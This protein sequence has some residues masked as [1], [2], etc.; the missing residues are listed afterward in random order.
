MKS[1]VGAVWLS[2]LLPMLG[3][4]WQ[5]RLTPPVPGPF[6][7]LRVV[8]AEYGFGWNALPAAE[9]SF[10]FSHQ[11]GGQLQLALRA[12][13]TGMVRLMWL[14]DA[15]HTAVARAGT[16]RPIR[17]N[18][19]I[20]YA[21]ESEKTTVR[22]GPA[23]VERRHETRPGDGQPVKTK[24]FKF[25][26]AFDLHT[27]FLFVRSQRLRTGDTYRFVV[28]PATAAYLAQ[29][30]VIGRERMEAGGRMQDAIRLELKLRKV[31]KKLELERHEKFK[32]GTA[33]LS[34]DRDRL[35]LKARAEV[36]VGSVW[37]ELARVKFER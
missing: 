6:P 33:W 4:D 34:D 8:K 13:S 28:Y 35:L 9:A 3:E 22:F 18:Q 10:D 11:K 25:P 20:T 14:M 24:R 29:I 2:L 21:A 16:L 32:Q 15:Q 1:W 23:G 30:N 26:D 31:G 36:L 27:A 7:A 12:R 17:V 5:Q 19:T 37:L